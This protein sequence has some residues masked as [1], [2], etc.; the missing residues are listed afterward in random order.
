MNRILEVNEKLAYVVVE[1]GVTFFD[2]YNYLR[3]HRLDLWVSV[4]ALGWGSVVGNV[5]KQIPRIPSQSITKALSADLCYCFLSR[6]LTADT[7]ILHLATAS[8]SSVVWKWCCLRERF[9][10]QA[11]G[12]LL[13]HQVPMPVRIASDLRLTVC[14]FK[15][16]WEL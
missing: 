5:S 11:S 4:P 12:L 15:A 13:I 2:I 8:T 16:T 6:Q 10:G 1:P 7:V 3:E 9:S 14:S